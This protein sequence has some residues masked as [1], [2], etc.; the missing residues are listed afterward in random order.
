MAP[1]LHWAMVIVL[2][3]MEPSWMRLGR[4]TLGKELS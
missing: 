2:K 1:W 4:E 3:A